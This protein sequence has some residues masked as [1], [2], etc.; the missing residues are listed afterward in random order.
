MR[1]LLELS[2]APAH[3][4]N[5]SKIASCLISSCMVLQ[6]H[7]TLTRGLPWRSL[8]LPRDTTQAVVR[9]YLLHHGYADTLHAFDRTCTCSADSAQPPGEQV[10][11]GKQ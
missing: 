3:H 10:A 6:M 4:L 9:D 8:D 1:G 5:D 2:K 11:N 7:V